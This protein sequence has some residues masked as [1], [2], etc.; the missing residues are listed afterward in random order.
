MYAVVTVFAE[1]AISAR[2][3]RD[4]LGQNAGGPF[5][6]IA[7]NARAM[8]KDHT[9]ADHARRNR[10]ARRV[11]IDTSRVAMIADHRRNRATARAHS[12][13]RRSARRAEKLLNPFLVASAQRHSPTRRASDTRLFLVTRA[14][15][16]AR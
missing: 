9:G 5:S 16:D 7:Q 11:R 10:T 4:G 13:Q 12:L 3:P 14:Q 6:R 8:E 2:A 15:S 1:A